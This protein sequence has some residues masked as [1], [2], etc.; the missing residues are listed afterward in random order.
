MIQLL[1][2][3]MNSL[4]QNIIDNSSPDDLAAKIEATQK[5][6]LSDSFRSSKRLAHD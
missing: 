4:M 5:M 2:S 6:I 3:A 1:G